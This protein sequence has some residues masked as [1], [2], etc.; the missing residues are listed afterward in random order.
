MYFK[1]I[2]E[3]K[4]KKFKIESKNNLEIEELTRKIELNPEDEENYNRRGIIFDEIGEYEKAI[5]DYTKAI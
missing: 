4:D 2:N 1:N 5:A 3:Y